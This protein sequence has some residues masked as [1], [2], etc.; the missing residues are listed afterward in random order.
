MKLPVP[1][2][3]LPLVLLHLTTFRAYCQR[4]TT[5][6]ISKF[7]YSHVLTISEPTR[8]APPY[9]VSL[10]LSSPDVCPEP[11]GPR[12]GKFTVTHQ[13]EGWYN[14]RYGYSNYSDE[15]WWSNPTGSRRTGMLNG[16]DTTGQTPGT[17]PYLGPTL[18]RSDG[19]THSWYVGTEKWSHSYATSCKVLLQHVNPYGGMRSVKISATATFYRWNYAL[20]E[21]V[22]GG[23][24][25]P[26]QIRIQGRPMNC[27]GDTIF[28]FGAT[29]P[30]NYVDIT[31]T[32]P[33]SYE[34]YSFTIQ[35]VP[36]MDHHRTRSYHPLLGADPGHIGHADMFTDYDSCIRDDDPNIDKYTRDDSVPV[37][38]ELFTYNAQQVRFPPPFDTQEYLSIDRAGALYALADAPFSQVKQVKS[39]KTPQIELLGFAKPGLNMVLC[40]NPGPKAWLHELGHN[41]GLDHRTSGDV[42]AALLSPWNSTGM[43]INRSERSALGR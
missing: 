28:L 35:A 21:Y 19:T 24:V 43:E 8:K 11:N 38:G 37:A 14:D 4:S 6:W 3:L 26:E 25:P 5:V 18:E 22:Y 42:D 27:N 32:L 13:M 10:F 7:E 20:G 31:P 30:G 9:L 12:S 23:A 16:I 29:S 36:G 33:A 34:Y 15:W 2:L 1:V 17:M 39:I 40:G 41:R